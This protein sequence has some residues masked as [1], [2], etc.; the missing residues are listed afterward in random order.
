MI[1]DYNNETNFP[2]KL[3]LSDRKVSRLYKA[4]ANNSSA[5]INWSKTRVSKIVQTGGVLGTLLGPLLKTDF[6]L[7]KY[8]LKPLTKIVLMPLG[9]KTTA[10]ATDA[11]IQKRFFGL[12]VT[13]LIISKKKWMIPSK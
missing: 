3:L 5:N 8:V 9:L 2:Y 4:F 13:A 12:V 7:M 6:P 11:A 1:D 10:W